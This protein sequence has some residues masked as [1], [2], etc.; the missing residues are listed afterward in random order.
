MGR[1]H[2]LEKGI[3]RIADQ[4]TLPYATF[5]RSLVDFSP[6][7]HLTQNKNLGEQHNSRIDLPESIE[8]G[9]GR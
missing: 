1:L 6:P 4:D 9:V 5:P 7:K 2:I 3:G 8:Q